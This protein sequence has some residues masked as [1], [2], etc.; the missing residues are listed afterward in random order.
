M[1]LREKLLLPVFI[2]VVAGMI[3][4][5]SYLYTNSADAI[6]NEIQKSIENEVTLSVNHIDSWIEGRVTDFQAWSKQEV[7]REALTEK[8]YYGKSA[9]A[10]ASEVLATLAKGYPYYSYIFMADENGV[11]VS[12]SSQ[13]GLAEINV[14]DRDYFKKS[15]LGESCISKVLQSKKSGNMI[16]VVSVPV[17]HEGRV[18][19]VLAGTIAVAEFRSLFV[20]SINPGKEGFA[21]LAESNGE[22]FLSTPK[23]FFVKRIAEMEFGE[24]M[25]IQRSGMLVQDVDGVTSVICFKK[26]NK[27]G[28]IMAEAKSLDMAL[29]PINKTRQYSVITSVIVLLFILLANS[30][31]FKRIIHTPLEA[32]LK[33]IKE[34]NRGNLN[35]QIPVGKK[36]D[37]IAILINAFNAMVARLKQTLESLTREVEE[38]KTAE[39]ELAQHRDNLE[40]L[41]SVRTLALEKEHNERKQLEARLHMAEKMEAIGTLAGGV[42]HDLNN[43]LSGIL[44]YPELILMD[45]PEDSLIR[46]QVKT[47]YNS[48]KKAAAIV[49]DLLTLARRGVH[50][51]EVSNMNALVKDYVSSPEFE[52]MISYHPGVSV[53]TDLEEKLYNTAC[54]PVHLATTIMNL[55][56]NAAESMPDGGA[57]TISTMNRFIESPLKG[58]EHVAVGNYSV[59]KVSDTGV[60]ISEKDIGRIYEPFYTKKKMGRSGT[61][62]GMAVVWGTVKDH[63][64]YIVCDSVEG[65]GTTFTLCF[66]AS[67]KDPGQIDNDAMTGSYRGNGETVL[68]IDDVREQREIASAIIKRLGYDVSVVSSGEEAIEYLKENRVDILVLDMI[69]D[70]G[71]DGLETFEKI[72]DIYPNQ[73][74][75]IASGF[76]ETERIEK[77]RALGAGCY[78]SKPYTIEAISDAIR[79]ELKK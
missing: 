64:G 30:I 63:N 13:G 67:G 31:M 25:I 44:S 4:T 16:F 38:R 8:G 26:V 32:T 49:Q 72:V 1:R 51:T 70:P 47:I 20:D 17:F 39:N 19:G 54:S 42:A 7:Y 15:M 37:E 27:T 2:T 46:P 21:F 18:A 33:V 11:I 60:G 71:M 50:V 28:W 48:G 78:I 73:K 34:V 52:K 62:L 55:V 6:L 3:A 23:D 5:V 22:V 75:I 74:A 24:N 53:K 57:I 69:M 59:L 45:L 40:T 65:E 41:V 10:G 56:S 61:G 76:S 36:S 14:L 35:E 43:I 58:Y 79:E 66:H 12:E 29:A 68:V 77:T 9:R